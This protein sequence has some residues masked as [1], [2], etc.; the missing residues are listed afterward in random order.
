MVKKTI[1][2]PKEKKRF[3][4]ALPLT[5]VDVQGYYSMEKIDATS[6]ASERQAVAFLIARQKRA[7]GLIIK[8]L[9]ND[10]G[11]AE[12]FAFEVPEFSSEDELSVN[13]YQILQEMQTA[14]YLSSV[15]GGNPRA[16]FSKAGKILKKAR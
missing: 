13:Q 14:Y 2:N 15:Y 10:F 11:G 16:Y 4:V 6:A 9:D 3:I 7:T 5:G 12:R 1:V 8:V